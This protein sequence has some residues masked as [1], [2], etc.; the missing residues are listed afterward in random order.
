MK[1]FI[2]VLL[3]LLSFNLMA[4]EKSEWKSLFDGKT[5]K[6]WKAPAGDDV[7]VVDGEIHMLTKKNIWMLHEETYENFELEVEAKMPEGHYNGGIGFRLT[8]GKKKPVGYQCEV[9]EKKS[10]AIY[11]IGKGWV[12]PA[13]KNGW[14]S[15][16][17]VA[18]D[19]FKTGEWNKFKI[20]VEG[21]RIQ[22]WVNGIQTADIK[23]DKY[24]K[25]AIALQHHG[26]GDVY[27]YKSIRIKKL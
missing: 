23:D 26:K 1:K 18:K 6:G 3:L 11:A 25:G 16:Y 27:K 8:S 10:G 22:I 24:S 5:L 9:D 21:Q 19:S 12:L 17:A 20:R 4:A 13:K 14:E 2:S 7:K 15:F